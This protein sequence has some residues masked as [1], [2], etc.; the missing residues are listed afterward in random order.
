MRL[1]FTYS[2]W[3]DAIITHREANPRFNLSTD[4]EQVGIELQFQ[5]SL[6]V[7]K[8]R[9]SEQYFSSDSPEP[10]KTQA[11]HSATVREQVA[12]LVEGVAKKANLIRV[13]A[14]TIIDWLGSGGQPVEASVAFERAM[15][16]CDCPLNEPT[17]WKSWATAVLAKAIKSQLEAAA[18]MKLETGYD[19]RLHTC[20]ACMCV[21]KLKV[22]CPLSHIHENMHIAAANKKGVLA[23]DLDPRCWILK[24]YS[25]PSA[26]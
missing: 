24:G 2:E 8:V 10:P 26:R 14:S 19:G 15:I 20:S 4:R 17:D 21:L 1:G 25:P 12:T 13:G 22:W 11:L 5:T 16:C 23:E 3:V 9:G 6:A 7:R 18:Q